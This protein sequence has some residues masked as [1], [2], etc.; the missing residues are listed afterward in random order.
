[1]PWLTLLTSLE[2]FSPQEVVAWSIFR[3]ID[4]PALTRKAS[5]PRSTSW[6]ERSAIN[7][8]PAALVRQ[9]DDPSSN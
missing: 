5:L 8:K 9:I 2:P 4:F 6:R 1:M 7:E 3:S